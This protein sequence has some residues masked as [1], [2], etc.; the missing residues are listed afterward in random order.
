MVSWRQATVPRALPECL[1]RC[2]NVNRLPDWRRGRSTTVMSVFRLKSRRPVPDAIR[3][4]RTS[5]ASSDPTQLTPGTAVSLDRDVKRSADAPPTTPP[6]SHRY[7][8][9]GRLDGTVDADAAAIC[10]SAGRPSLIRVGVGP[11]LCCLRTTPGSP[12]RVQAPTSVVR[13]P[14]GADGPRRMPAR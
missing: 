3:P 8:V 11:D 6:S 4:V 12:P 5:P 9:I 1:D 10:R 7:P 14:G 13:C 2:M